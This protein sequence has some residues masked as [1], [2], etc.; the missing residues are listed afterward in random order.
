MSKGPNV[1]S[2]FFKIT[3]NRGAFTKEM[4]GTASS[5][6]NTFGSAMKAVGKSIG[7]AFSVGSVVAFGKK[8]VQVASETQSAWTGLGSIINGQG[9]DFNKAKSFIQNYIKDGLVPL[10][11][12]VTAYKNLAARGYDQSQ[13]E[14]VMNALKDSAAFGRQI[15]LSYGE[16]I[17]SATEGL[18][19]ENSILVDN[20]GIT[21]NVAKMWDEYAKS[22]GTTSSA[23]TQQQKIQAEVN[24]ILQETR[25]QTGDAT[26]YSQ[27]FAGGI[28]RITAT[29]T[30]LKTAIGNTLIPVLNQFLPLI[31]AGLELA[32]DFCNA[33]QSVMASL[34]WEMPDVSD[35]NSAIGS[36][37]ADA[38]NASTATEGIGTAAETAAKKAK[39]AFA[40][41]DEIN[42]L[43]TQK[44]VTNTAGGS[45]GAVN[46]A[47]S[48]V[49]A[50]KLFNTA[51][52][53]EAK[54]KLEKIIPVVAEIAAGFAAWKLSEKLVQGIEWLKNLKAKDFSWSLN[55]LGAANFVA[56]LDMLRRCVEDGNV[57]GAI[58]QFAGLIGD[59]LT[60][61]GNLKFASA[62]KAL[63][64]IGEIVTG[65][66][67]LANNGTNINDA[68]AVVRGVS[69]VFMAVGL[70]TQN[71]KIVGAATTLQGLTTVI[72]ELATNWEAIKKG[73]WSGVD[74]ATLVIGAI[75]A[76]VGIGTA[77]GSLK[78]VKDVADTAK[79]T[80]AVKGVT[81]ATDSVS[82]AV[83][84]LT[85]KLSNLAKNLG[86]GILIIAEVAVAAGLFLG[87]IWGIGKLLEETGKA[88][89]P[90]IDNGG[91]V[92]AAVG[93][94]TGILV[95]VGVA[96][97]LLGTATTSSGGT[98]PLAIA[99]GAAMLLEL[100]LAAGLFVGEIV[101]IG[102]LLDEVGKAWTPVTKQG[103]VVSNAIATGTEILISIG[104]VTA[105]LGAAAVASAGLLP[106]AI[107]LGTAMLVE[108]TIA[109]LAFC[110]SML[111]VVEELINL[112]KPLNELNGILPTMKNDM[113][114]FTSFMGD[115]AGAVIAFTSVSAIAGIAAT[116][117]TVIDF[118]TTDPIDRMYRE[119]SDQTAEFENLIPA[120]ETINP[121]IQK[122]TDLV[123]VYKKNMGSFESAT[124][125]SGG[126]LNSIVNGA[127][128][129][130][131]GLIGMFE[132]MANSVIRC[133]NVL[134][135]GL[136]RITF[137]VPDW[138]PGI[139]GKRL[140]FNI[141]TINEVRIPRLAQGGW[142]AANNPQL[143]IIG[144]NRREGEIVTPESK[145][146][147]QVELALAKFSGMTQKVKLELEVL[148]RY[149]DG[150]TI[151]KRI[152]EA[153]VAEGRILLEV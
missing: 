90:V 117:D 98:L 91:T 106:L 22:I 111:T 81:E 46:V 28:A 125:G 140:G 78:K 137:N 145:I 99:V 54:Q 84:S 36:V 119:V 29:A 71:K 142:V 136:N 65:I 141:S 87:A 151:I 5:V 68:L 30:Q 10:N 3:S 49:A 85:P 108:L 20:V 144:D 138:V 7:V 48:A 89:Q 47:A 24:G 1:G 32:L 153:Q 114:T 109:F 147:E 2:V 107:G 110:N 112:S 122:A 92:A 129:V 152:N 67:S 123:G 149:P 15:S 44:D 148:I 21:K 41:F 100:G 75:Q 88:W 31:Q 146:R 128:G 93:I 51:E 9:K 38:V 18:K 79:T 86:L 40:S 27:T 103:E 52:I 102:K 63:Q 104:V 12:A 127:K 66:S 74:K 39:K 72:R 133:I 113:D 94:G 61:M 37:S 19:N 55:I 150:R 25:W 105:A 64:G 80:D 116:I 70:F 42:T 53:D 57:A 76:V 50:P 45:T 118:F 77:L 131:N 13:I 135:S 23:L 101:V 132:G 126:F 83:S 130:V 73:D 69:N 62:F 95:A 58:S 56:D 115:F 139:G 97:A 17:Q 82:N 34:G 33:M 134:I 11:N 120:L 59:A 26:K 96:C 4:K 16:A 60:M 35:F 143:A 8:C 43:N 6:Q 121:M 124:G 14:S